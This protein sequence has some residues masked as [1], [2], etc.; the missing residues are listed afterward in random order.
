MKKLF[1]INANAGKKGKISFG[2]KIRKT[3]ALSNREN[4]LEV[5]VTK[6]VDEARAVIC[7]FRDLGGKIVYVCGGDGS[8]GAVIGEFVGSSMAVGLI[9]MGTGNDFSK[10]FDYKNF[11]IEKTFEPKIRLIDAFRVNDYFC[12]NIFSLGYDTEVLSRIYEYQKRFPNAGK[13]NFFMGTLTSLSNITKNEYEIKIISPSGE[14]KLNCSPSILT[15][16]N[17][18]Y[19]GSGFFP[20]VNAKFDDGI[21]NLVMINKPSLFQLPKTIIDYRSGNILNNPNA[22][23][24]TL[25]SVEIKSHNEVLANVDGAIFKASHFKAEVIKKGVNWAF[26]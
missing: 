25:T 23:E 20:G 18:S 17:G 2:E 19:Y 26:F 11:S 9:P 8:I 22:E 12:I 13:L 21:L 6:S 14:K 1:L 16:C 24:F 3:Y 7:K 4:E 5:A 10:N 15:V